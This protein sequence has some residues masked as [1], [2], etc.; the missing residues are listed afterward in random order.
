M[1]KI[2]L[3]SLKKRA[4]MKLVWTTLGTRLRTEVNFFFFLVLIVKRK[5]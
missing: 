1:L 3:T 2:G 5:K 4:G